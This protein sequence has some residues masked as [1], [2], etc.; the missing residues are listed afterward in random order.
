MHVRR[1]RSSQQCATLMVGQRPTVTRRQ[2]AARV[3]TRSSGQPASGL[4]GRGNGYFEV[5]SATGFLLEPGA[6]KLSRRSISS[7]TCTP[8]RR[9]P[10]D[11]AQFSAGKTRALLCLSTYS[12]TSQC[13]SDM[14]ETWER[15]PTHLYATLHLVDRRQ[16]QCRPSGVSNNREDAASSSFCCRS[17]LPR[18]I[19]TASIK[20]RT[21]RP[22]EDGTR[23]HSL[24]EEGQSDFVRIKFRG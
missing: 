11:L 9:T 1:K 4:D 24:L 18:A 3:A 7:K 22:S 17:S 13:R 23:Q 14:A 20:A 6:S 15:N 16:A 12:D 5:A 8:G 21:C 19:S 2:T 10:A